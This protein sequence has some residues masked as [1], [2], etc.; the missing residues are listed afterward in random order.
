[1]KKL[2]ISAQNHY[3]HRQSQYLCHQLTNTSILNATLH[4]NLH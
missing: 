4:V 2:L 3:C 1:M